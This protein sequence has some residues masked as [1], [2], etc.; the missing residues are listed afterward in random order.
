ML[1]RASVVD[2]QFIN[3]LTQADFP[4]SK[5]VTRPLDVGM[6]K[7]RRLNCLILKLNRVCWI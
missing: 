5:T 7:K 1:D 4:Q 2:A 6:D 3:R